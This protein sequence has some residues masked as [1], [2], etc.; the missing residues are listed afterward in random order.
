MLVTRNVQPSLWES[1]LPDV[2][3]KLPAELEAVDRLLDDE[4][5]FAPFRAHF[6][7]LIGRPSVPMETYL[8][9]MFLKFRH[10]I[11]YETLCRE[12]SD[13]ISWRLFCHIDI[14]A[15]VPHPTTLMKITTRCGEATVLAL[16]DALLAKAVAAKVVRT[17]KVRADTT[18]VSA[19]VEYPT[20]SGLLATA[21]ARIG[22]LVRRIK[23]TGGATRTGF[24]DRSR[25]AASKVHAIGAK[26]RLRGA[27]AREQAQATVMRITGELADLARHSSTDAQRILAN[28][29]RA[30]RKATGQ[31]KG[32]LHRAINE[33]TTVIERTGRI[34]AQTHQRLAGI[35]PDS[36][37]RLVS[38]HDPQAH[39]IVKGGLGKPVE[40]GYKGQV[41]DNED[42]IVLD[43][44]VEEGNPPDAPQLAP[45]IARVKRRTG[46]TPRKVTAD[47]GYGEP[48]VDNELEELGVK[49]V[50]IPRKG[51]PGQARRDRE[52]SR[53][54]RDMVKWRT[55][56]EGRISHLKHRFGWARTLMDART[57][58]AI[59]CGHGVL[60]H[61]L[62]KVAGLTA[63]T[64]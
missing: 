11:G 9:L 41:V 20:D 14:D 64:A 5:F 62:V 27:Q 60:T 50:A 59:W 13:S 7:P 47:R 3:L 55:G 63:K 31:T 43:Y 35:K 38:L 33:L 58:A 10:R 17:G 40:F 15:R 54:F 56:I 53:G 2:V 51:Q 36:A 46:S 18:V 1:V 24:R 26:L 16:N 6:D 48:K 22:K 12:V 37:T 4:A 39:P 19:N 30:L 8:R 32:R 28:A 21:V 42:G 34:M 61:N 23:A 57:G 25:S 45:A 29:R 52:H 44:T 49:D